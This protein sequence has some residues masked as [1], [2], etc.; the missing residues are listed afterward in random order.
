MFKPFTLQVLGSITIGSAFLFA[1]SAQSEPRLAQFAE[2]LKVAEAGEAAQT[3]SVDQLLA[4]LPV[5]VTTQTSGLGDQIAAGLGEYAKL[6]GQ[7]YAAF[8]TQRLTREPWTA[9][10]KPKV[11]EGDATEIS[12]EP[13][14]GA[15]ANFPK[16]FYGPND[17]NLLTVETHL[18]RGVS[19]QLFS[20]LPEEVAKDVIGKIR[21]E[22]KIRDFE[23]LPKAHNYQHAED[24]LGQIYRHAYETE[25][26]L[27]AV[28]LTGVPES[29]MDRLVVSHSTFAYIL[30]TFLNEFFE[31]K[32]A[33]SQF[34]ALTRTALAIGSL[35]EW[36]TDGIQAI[37]N[38][39][40]ES[41][42]G[43]TAS[44]AARWAD[45]MKDAT[46]L[47]A[48]D[49]MSTENFHKLIQLNSYWRNISLSQSRKPAVPEFE[50][51]AS[52][53]TPEGRKLALEVLVES[54]NVEKS[55]LVPELQVHQAPELIEEDSVTGRLLI[56][57]FDARVGRDVQV[58]RTSVGT[59][60]AFP[61]D[62]K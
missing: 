39:I 11:I 18:V 35:N 51:V 9:S 23:G 41:N 14:Y 3:K 59:C 46:R 13:I 45:F 49:G 43:N 37:L 21:F 2:I 38:Q 20:S 26:K 55:L 12:V 22:V 34:S 48:A 62:G 58:E 52:L 44:L 31:V 50:G 29:M 54:A 24:L 15:S 25:I 16:Q 8:H 5:P 42:P 27:Q 6:I 36:S 19:R 32:P 17:L 56:S 61:I 7:R 30:S 53:A 33:Q 10:Y 47:A 1:S 4:V 28:R 57:G 60:R 40:S